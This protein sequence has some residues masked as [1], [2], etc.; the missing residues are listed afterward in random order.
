MSYREIASA[1]RDWTEAHGLRLT[2][3]WAGGEM[4]C[5]DL[6][7][8][9]GQSFRIAIDR[10]LNGVT[11]VRL[12]CVEGWTQNDP[13]QNWVVEA[14]DVR[15]ALEEALEEVLRQMTVRW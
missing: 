9:D 4:L 15:E 11:G 13:H 14:A 7:S 6:S 1:V 3:C 5:A 12:V 2:T 8:P 10:P